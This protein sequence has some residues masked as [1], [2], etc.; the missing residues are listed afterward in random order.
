M[1]LCES[2]YSARTV[3]RRQEYIRITGT[4]KLTE[5][6]CCFFAQAVPFKE[7]NVVMNVQGGPLQSSQMELLFSQMG[8]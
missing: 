2:H 5:C 7:K 3:W 8:L 4:W 6:L 1:C